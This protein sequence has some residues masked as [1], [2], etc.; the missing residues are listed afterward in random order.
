[1][2]LAILLFCDSIIGSG[3]SGKPRAEAPNEHGGGSLYYYDET[4]NPFY[5]KL[6]PYYK[7]ADGYITGNCTWYAWGRA[8]EIAGKRLSHPFTGDAGTWWETNQK[9]GWYPYGTSP[10]RGAIA[11]Y[12]THVGI[13][14]QVDPL[15]VS[16][17]GWTVEKQK[18]PVVFH[19]GKPWHKEPKGYIYPNE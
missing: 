19:C 18:G 13:V 6:A 16:E 3:G 4:V 1:M 7:T 14:E 9:E 11:C 17:S 2:V 12:E 5:P 8:C 10:K 15:I